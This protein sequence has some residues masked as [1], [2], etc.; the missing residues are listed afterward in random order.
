MTSLG[1]CLEDCRGL[2]TV[3]YTGCRMLPG[4]VDVVLT[5]AANWANPA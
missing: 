3:V 4:G 1:C 2:G 5:A